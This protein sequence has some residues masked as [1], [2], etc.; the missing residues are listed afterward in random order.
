LPIFRDDDYICAII[1]KFG[2]E[3]CL[4]VNVQIQHRGSDRSRDD[5]S[6]ECSGSASAP[7]NGSAKKHPPKH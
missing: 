7:K 5:H 4:N 2:T 6:Q 1:A 3:L